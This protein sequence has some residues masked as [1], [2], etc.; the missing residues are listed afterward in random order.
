[1]ISGIETFEKYRTFFGNQVALPKKKKVFF[2]G[3]VVLQR[4]WGSLF[5]GEKINSKIWVY[6]ATQV[7]GMLL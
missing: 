7:G 2:K 4:P 3:L 5:R 1:L 6:G